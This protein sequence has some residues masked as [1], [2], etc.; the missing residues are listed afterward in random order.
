MGTFNKTQDGRFGTTNNPSKLVPGPGQYS[1]KTQ[2]TQTGVYFF[3]KWKNAGT[4]T[5]YHANRKTIA[6]PPCA[7][8]TPGPGYYK[9]PSEFGYYE[10]RKKFVKTA[11]PGRRGSKMKESASQPQIKNDEGKKEL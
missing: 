9:A 4:R 6:L 11:K 7:K 3:S 1:P 2:M 8:I 5:F 10:S